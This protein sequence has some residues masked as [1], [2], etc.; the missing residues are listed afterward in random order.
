MAKASADEMRAGIALGDIIVRRNTRKTFDPEAM[1]ELVASVKEHGVLQ[2]VIVRHGPD[3]TFILVAGER[4]IRAAREAGVKMIPAVL[5]DVTEEEAIEIQAIENLQR[6]DLHPME[7]AEAY[8]LLHQNLPVEEIAAKVGKGKT[9]VYQRLALLALP[10]LARDAY[11]DEII[12]TRQA[13]LFARIPNEELREE[14]AKAILKNVPVWVKE[15]GFI[16]E[17]LRD[18]IDRRFMRQLN[19]AP[20][21][22]ADAQLVKAAG[23]CADCPKRSGNATDLFGELEDADVC[24]DSVCYQRKSVVAWNRTKKT[25]KKEG[26]ATID[27]KPADRIFP[28]GRISSQTKFVELAAKCE[29]DPKRRT[30]KALLGKDAAESITLVRPSSGTVHEVIER[31]EALRIT[32]QRGHTFKDKPVRATTSRTSSISAAEKRQRVETRLRRDV[33]DEAIKELTKVDTSELRAADFWSG[34][35]RAIAEQALHDVAREI[36]RARNLPRPEK[37]AT[38]VKAWNKKAERDIDYE[39]SDPRSPRGQLE[40]MVIDLEADGDVSGLVAAAAEIL[41]RRFAVR[42]WYEG[43]DV[44]ARYGIPLRR[45]CLAFGVDLE[46]ID[47]RLRAEAVKAERAKASKAKAKKKKSTRAKVRKK[48][49]TKRRGKKA[50]A[51]KG[52]AS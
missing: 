30:W 33:A 50:P 24:L 5:K 10:D 20:F 52:G 13:L 14:A 1:D 4:R 29:Q 12:D 49:I 31:K 27:G 51:R 28:H 19:Q 6:E 40:R 34:V 39:A 2:P 23:A 21:D 17:E 25:A 46:G 47:A 15:E 16:Y 36:V 37:D 35:T 3:G 22:I 38:E 44:S 41:A 26:R 9:Y 18:D 45:L 7:E 11:R 48:K 42:H 32:K 43:K 8:E